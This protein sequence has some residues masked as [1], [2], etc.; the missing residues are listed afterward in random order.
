MKIASKFKNLLLH[1][2]V[3]S[4]AFFVFSIVPSSVLA[5]AINFPTTKYCPSDPP[6]VFTMNAPTAF[7]LTGYIHCSLPDSRFDTTHYA[8][9]ATQDYET[10]LACGAC[11]VLNNGGNAT[12]DVLVDE[13][14]ASSNAPCDPTR[15]GA[16]A[17]HQ[18]Y[19]SSQTYGALLRPPGLMTY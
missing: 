13:W 11:A 6:S 18:L 16:N 10:G 4:L 1:S 15:R 14:P 19:L 12:T 7:A 2:I 5:Q 3:F 8:A 17:G 9:L